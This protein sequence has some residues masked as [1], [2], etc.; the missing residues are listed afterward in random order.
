M[1][2]PS[3]P[4]FASTYAPRRRGEVLPALQVTALRFGEPEAAQALRAEGTTCTFS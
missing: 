1:R 2:G 3:L 4:G